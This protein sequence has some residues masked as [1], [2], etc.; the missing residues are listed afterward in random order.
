M[1]LLLHASMEIGDLICECRCQL[2]I[3]VVRK[4][5]DKKININLRINSHKQP[6]VEAG[7]LNSMEGRKDRVK[8]CT[9]A[10]NLM[11]IFVINFD[12]QA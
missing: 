6:F 12:R 8:M 7:D 9:V 3:L 2:C 10:D 4:S 5:S 11:Q 1:V